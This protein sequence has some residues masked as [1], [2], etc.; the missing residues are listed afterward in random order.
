MAPALPVALES[1]LSAPLHRLDAR[2]GCN[3]SSVFEQ[4]TADGARAQATEHAL[5]GNKARATG[6]LAQDNSTEIP[7]G[8]SVPIA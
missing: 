5:D 6:A 3:E 8:V 7:V 4:A 2:G 1:P